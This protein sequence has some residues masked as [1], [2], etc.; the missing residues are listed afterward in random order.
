MIKGTEDN[1]N[2]LQT[3]AESVGV[4]IQPGDVNLLALPLSVE[5]RTIPNRLVIQPMEG[6]DA[7]PD[8][9]PDELT[10]RRYLRY[11]RGG[12]GLIW[13]EAVALLPELKSNARQLV[14][15]RQTLDGF[16]ALVSEIKEAALR[17]NAAEP[18]IIIQLT[19]PGRSCNPLPK[20]ATDRDIW[21][22]FRPSLGQKALTDNAIE[23]LAQDYADVAALAKIAGIDGVEVK[24][25]HFYF[26]SELLSAFERPGKYG[27]S[28]E[29]RTR[30]LKEAVAAIRAKAPEL[31]VTT[32]LNLY[33]GLPHPYGFGMKEGCGFTPDH[34]EPLKLLAE[35]NLDY[36]VELVNC[37]SAGPSKS[38]FPD[39]PG[40]NP[41]FAPSSEPLAGG[42]RMH[43][44]AAQTKKALPV[45]KVVATGFSHLRQHAHLVGAAMIDAGEADLIGFGR[46]AFAYPDFARDILTKGELDKSKICLCCGGCGRLL[47]SRTRCIGCI[48]RDREIYKAI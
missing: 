44:L 16:C 29:N 40:L 35:L 20:P 23:S 21:D 2:N 13:M 17:E 45:M 6:A 9:A 43:Y 48:L 1:F 22:I 15:S 47:G 42:A 38:V 41:L 10:L 4:N 33:D 26:I 12:A 11:A 7:T 3:Y 28:Y 24:A 37:S 19:H 34:S 32:R 14:L 18:I 25:C 36:G 27:G 46:Q 31:I 8:G 5:G 39:A 30:H